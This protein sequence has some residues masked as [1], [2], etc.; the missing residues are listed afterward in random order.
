MNKRSKYGQSY[1]GAHP[2]GE[3]RVKIKR[4]TNEDAKRYYRCWNCG[5]TIDSERVKTDGEGTTGFDAHV[6]APTVARIGSSDVYT[7]EIAGWRE[8]GINLL[9]ADGTP[10]MPKVVYTTVDSGGCPFCNTKNWK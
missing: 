4:G 10:Q 3:K 1:G 9:Y 6:V 2:R 8:S 7:F 5:F